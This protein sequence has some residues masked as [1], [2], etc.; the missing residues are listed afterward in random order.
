[1]RRSKP[2]WSWEFG[3]T[4]NVIHFY[5]TNGKYAERDGYSA[6]DAISLVDYLNHR[7]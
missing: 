4:A 2:L 5:C 1:M 6:V 7:G 3:A